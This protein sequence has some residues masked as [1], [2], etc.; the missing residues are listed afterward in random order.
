[1]EKDESTSSKL[2]KIESFASTKF[3]KLLEIIL[4]ESLFKV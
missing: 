2:E 3:L 4:Q 1:M